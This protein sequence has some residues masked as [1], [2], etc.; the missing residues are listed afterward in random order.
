M[1]PSYFES[2]SYSPSKIIGHLFFQN[3]Y[4]NFS[5][6]K[7]FHDDYLIQI[8]N[9]GN[10]SFYCN[11]GNYHAVPGDIVLINPGEIHNGN[12]AIDELLEYNVFYVN[13]SAWANLLGN[14]FNTS[15]PNTFLFSKTVVKDYVLFSMI[16]RYFKAISSGNA[17]ESYLYQ[18]LDILTYITERYLSIKP[19][20]A[21]PHYYA[22][23]IES[24][25]EYIC[26]NLDNKLRLEELAKVAAIS[27]FHL[28]RLFTKYTGI[29]LHQFILVRRIEKAKDLLKNK[30]SISD[31]CY[32]LGFSDQSHFTRCF[33]R[34]IGLTPRQY[35][36]L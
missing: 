31:V 33:K 29:T 2:R 15:S 13:P 6:P 5:F 23:T 1:K 7:H 11:G 35:Q 14:D 9:K 27:P 36:M 3:N 12:C 20:S 4:R 19:K 16:D 25:K 34:M 32:T 26:D 22:E 18:Y 30:Y 10:N 21:L 28:L 17:A 8:I 24:L